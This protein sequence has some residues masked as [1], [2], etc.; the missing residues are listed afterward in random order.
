V[1]FYESASAFEDNRAVL[2]PGWKAPELFKKQTYTSETLSHRRAYAISITSFRLLD[3]R[4]PRHAAHVAKER[5][6]FLFILARLLGVAK[7]GNLFVLDRRT[8][9]PIALASRAI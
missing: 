7:T 5:E 6:I 1:V 9:E 3:C 8:G 2:A 4:Y